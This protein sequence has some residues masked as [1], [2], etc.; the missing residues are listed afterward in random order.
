MSSDFLHLDSGDSDYFSTPQA[1]RVRDKNPLAG[2]SP[3]QKSS[4]RSEL[5]AVYDKLD[6]PVRGNLTR[7]RHS[8]ATGSTDST[9]SRDQISSFDISK[10]KADT[11]DRMKL[12]NIIDSETT[13]DDTGDLLFTSTLLETASEKFLVNST[14]IQ[15]QVNHKYNYNHNQ[16]DTEVSETEESPFEITRPI[17]I[18][19]PVKHFDNQNYT[20]PGF[21]K[22]LQVDSASDH[23]ATPRSMKDFKSE[24]DNSK[25]RFRRTIM[26][27]VNSSP[28]SVRAHV[29]RP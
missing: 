25:T 22:L 16:S 29:K 17:R 24:L 2:F 21:G 1:S 3:Q 13:A 11:S 19:S 6:T 14:A 18:S 20:E 9:L 5:R 8:L 26:E 10:P 28:L 4:L 27:L 7:Q 15:T 23:L 12:S